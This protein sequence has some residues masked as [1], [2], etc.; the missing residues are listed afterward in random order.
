LGRARSVE[1]GAL[2][3]KEIRHSLPRPEIKVG[4]IMPYRGRLLLRGVTA[5]PRRL[6]QKDQLCRRHNV[7]KIIFIS[8]DDGYSPPK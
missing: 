3:A 6:L 8:Y 5:R 7:R 1:H 2:A 4:H